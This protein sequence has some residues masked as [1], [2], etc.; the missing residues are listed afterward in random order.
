[1][2]QENKEKQPYSYHTFIFPFL[3]NDSGRVTREQFKKCI[4]NGWLED[5]AQFKEGAP[6][7]ELYNQ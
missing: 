2:M 5:K 7:T 4:N 6:N 3:W 1:M